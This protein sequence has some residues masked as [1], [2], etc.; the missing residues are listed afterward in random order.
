M[1]ANMLVNM[2][3]NVTAAH[4]NTTIAIPLLSIVSTMGST[5]V[6]TV[7]LCSAQKSFY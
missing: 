5:Y 2:S 7:T 6:P 3:S 4:S 1:T